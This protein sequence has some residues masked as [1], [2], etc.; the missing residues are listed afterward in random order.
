ML[1]SGCT[2]PRILNI[3]ISDG[4]L[5]S[6]TLTAFSPGNE[7]TVPT[8]RLGGSHTRS[9]HGGEKHPAGNR[10]TDGRPSHCADRGTQTV[11]ELNAL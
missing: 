8:G 3:G 2:A 7:T 9:E 4:S 10:A 1:G 5:F 6:F 11:S